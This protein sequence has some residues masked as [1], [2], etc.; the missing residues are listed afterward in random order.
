M[1]QLDYFSMPLLVSAGENG[2]LQEVY[3][4]EKCVTGQD[5]WA[6]RAGDFRDMHAHIHS[7]ERESD[8]NTTQ[9]ERRGSGKTSGHWADL[10][11][12]VFSDAWV[13]VKG[14]I[15][16]EVLGFHWFTLWVVHGWTMW[17]I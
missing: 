10:R 7:K 16:W 5:T 9:I 8:K 13:G 14:R 6:D 15:H 12:R 2:K 1:T 4:P 17:W 11:L 3:D